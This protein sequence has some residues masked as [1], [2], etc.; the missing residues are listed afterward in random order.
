[1]LTNATLTM[2]NHNEKNQIDVTSKWKGPLAGVV[3]VNWNAAIDKSTQKIGV[4]AIARNHKGNVLAS[5]CSSKPYISDMTV[6]EAY[7]AWKVVKLYKR[8]EA[9]KYY[10]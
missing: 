10:S 2:R 1:M 5:L 9:S 3:R 6:A 7:A 4:G 8:L